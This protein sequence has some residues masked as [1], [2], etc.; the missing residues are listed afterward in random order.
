MK[1]VGE[2]LGFWVLLLGAAVGILY[3]IMAELLEI[4]INVLFTSR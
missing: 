4:P 3:G 2:A 1:K